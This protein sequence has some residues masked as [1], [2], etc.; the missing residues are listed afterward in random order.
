MDEDLPE[1][2]KNITMSKH[3]PEPDYKTLI[4]NGVSEDKLA[5]IKAIR[6][7]VPAKPRRYGV[8]SWVE[9]FNTA[10]RMANVVLENKQP[11]ETIS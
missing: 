3:F 2:V 9:T 8:K 4:D 5:I 10:R 1:D 6:D 11:T 7:N